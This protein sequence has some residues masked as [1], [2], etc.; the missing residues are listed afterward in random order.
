MSEPSLMTNIPSSPTPVKP[1][2]HLHSWV[3]DLILVYVLIVGAYFRFQG[4]YWGEYTYMHPDERFLLMVESDISPVKSLGEYFNTAQSSLNPQNR[5]HNFFVYGTFPIFL[6]RYLSEWI[7]GHSGLNEALQ[8]GRPLSAFFDWASI[9]LVYLVAARLYNKRVGVLAAAFYSFAVLPIQLSH[10]FKEDTFLNFFAL[11]A[12]YFAV[13]IMTWSKEKSSSSSDRLPVIGVQSA[14]T[15][16]Q[17]PGVS[18]QSTSENEQLSYSPQLAISDNSRITTQVSRFLT[19]PFFL[20]SIGFGVALGLAVASKLN[21]APVALVLPGAMVV[22]WL[23]LPAHERNRQ[24]I[25]LLFYLAIGAFTSFLTFRTAQP[26]AF[27]GPG[28]LGLK[29][30]PDWVQGIQEQRAQAAG[31]VDFP[32][33]LQWARRPLW[34]SWQ[35]LV[36]WGFGLPLGLLAWAGFLWLGWR[37]LKGEW[38]Q[39]SLLWGWTAF[40]F[41]WQ[42]IQFNPTMRYQLPIYPL[43]A[44]FAAWAVIT[45]YD[46]GW[47]INDERR[48]TKDESLPITV[49]GRSSFI[50]IIAVVIGG[51]VLLLT[52]AYA[53]AFTRIYARPFTRAD[54]SHWILKNIPGPINLQIQTPDGIINQPL[55]FPYDY[56]IRPGEP[57]S[58]PFTA[59]ATGTLSEIHLNAVVDPQ[60]KFGE[61]TFIMTLSTEPGGG[62]VTTASETINLSQDTQSSSQQ[63]FT[64]KSEFPVT[65]QQTYY[66]KLQLFPGDGPVSLSGSFEIPVQI[67]GQTITQTIP[68]SNAVVGAVNPYSTVFT[69]RSDGVLSGITLNSALDQASAPGEKTFS[70]SVMTPESS[71]QP[72]A[73]ASVTNDFSNAKGPTGDGYTLTLDRPVNLTKGENYSL[74]IDLQGNGGA[75]SLNGAEVAN[76]GDWDDGLPLR[77][78]GYDAFGGIYPPGLNFNMYWDDNQDK[79]NR[80]RGIL[81]NTEYIFMSS[82]RQWASLTRIPERFPL[83]TA[84]YRNLLGC[85]PEKDIIWCYSVAQP[86]Q[87]KGRLG[88]ELVKVFQSDPRLGPLQLNDQFAEE[89]FTV[90]DHPKVFIFRK[91]AVYDPLQVQ[92]ILGSVDLTKVIRI[93]PK[94]AASYPAVAPVLMLPADRLAEQRQGGTW[95]Q[96]FNPDAL[97]NRIEILGVILWY[98]SVTLL[99]LIAYP[100]MRLALPGLSDHGYPLA[101]TAG[102]LLLSYLVWL[103]GS[104]KIP[105]TRLT[106]SIVLVLLGLAG[107]YL[108]YRQRDGLRR[109]WKD[110]RRYFLIIEGVVLAF[111]IFDLLI[112]FGNPDLWHPWK[113][114]EKPMDFSYLNAV[115]KSTTFPPYDPWYAGGYLNYYY[116]GFVFVGVL[117]KLLGIMPSFAYNLILPTLFSMVALGAFSIT[118]NLYNHKRSAISDQQSTA[119]GGLSSPDDPQ[120]SVF[121]FKPYL[122][123]LAAAIGMVVIGNLGTVKMIL[124]G[125]QT[126]AASGGPVALDSASFLTRIGWTF[127][128]LLSTLKGTALP[129]S[130]G[131]WYWLPSRA[132][133]AP[134]DVEPITE[135]PFFTFLY[136]DLHAHMIS[137]TIMLLVLGWVVSVVLGRARWKGLLGGTFGFLMGGLALGALYPTNLSDRYTFLPLCAVA[138]GY[139]IWHNYIPNSGPPLL[140]VWANLPF[141]IRRVLVTIGGIGLLVILSLLLFR[142]YTQWYGQA[143][144]AVDAWKGTHTPLSAYLTHWGVFLFVIISWMVWET[145]DWLAKT[146]LSALRKLAPY[147]GVF[148]GMLVVI[149]GYIAVLILMLIFGMDQDKDLI[150]NSLVWWGA[151]VWLKTPIVWFVVPLMAWAGLLILRSGQSDPKRII[152]FLVGT[153]L[154][155]TLMV[156]V[157]VVRGDIGRMNT[158][159]KFYLQVWIFFGISAAAALGWL[160]S[161]LKL[162]LPSYRIVWKVAFTLLVASATLY[163]LMGGIAKIKDRMAVNAPH[164]L[165]GMVYIQYSTYNEQGT[166]LDL[167]RDYRAIRWMQENVKGSPVIVEANSGNLYRWYTR[168]TIYTGLPNV[169]GWEWHEQQQRALL[170]PDWVHQRLLEI[171]NFYLTTDLNQ[172]KDFLKKYDVSYIVFGQLEEVAYPA[173]GPEKFPA[174]DG[175]LWRAVYQ[176]GG[177]IIYEVIKPQG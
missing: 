95:S 171:N 151:I 41:A 68:I 77:V 96:L 161:E 173:A 163:T 16:N 49:I 21:A 55:P 93:T 177:T 27:S 71:D 36:V 125:Y 7:I 17:L 14:I 101:R 31:D 117:V 86:G 85:P 28:F 51:G 89:A 172:I 91:T 97:Q 160:W 100:I 13:C 59:N 15:G 154:A 132:I 30:N 45:L 67:S 98:L 108:A 138:L 165:D 130:L 38:R 25:Q 46:L 175:V 170:P 62:A 156:E 109:E 105:F 76:E 1:R 48:R 119:D 54:A 4:I 133:P 18:N 166:D 153:G 141:I 142:P 72:V 61:K 35:N 167:S 9:V 2:R 116:Y 118:W 74:R 134:N 159:F 137:L 146:P 87:F 135:F 56:L 19:H 112:R 79:L 164:T 6:T 150:N 73:T 37:I 10:F 168:F 115:L 155:L 52:L 127:Q 11:L 123:G 140:D 78:D 44:I 33:S 145:R 111:F 174:Y 70:V 113:G 136:A 144:A 3:Y 143:Y 66:I 24:V 26:Y 94:R 122:I 129:Y 157:I 128:G 114:G 23:K 58:S 50:R 64:F 126:L 47:N 110:N 43:L 75:V 81:N 42:S 63:T 39:H 53:F 40:Y 22:Y 65:R 158:V 152:L 83:T 82:N 34:F 84:Y 106:I 88:F 131:D 102:L 124:R 139:A 69:A 121:N 148:L 5:G 90:Y 147:K 169:L 8:V 103:A 57:F 120:P 149:G 29:P 104:Y 92:V 60:A 107:A 32:P 99:G 20:L 80:F 176:D 12:V 162:W